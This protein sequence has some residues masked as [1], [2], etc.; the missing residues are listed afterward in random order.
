MK[1]SDL[2]MGAGV[3]AFVGGAF[4]FSLWLGV[5]LVGMVVA[6]GGFALGKVEDGRTN[7]PTRA[8]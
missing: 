1:L 3:V 5:M 4:G 6:V 2:V 8:A 7:K